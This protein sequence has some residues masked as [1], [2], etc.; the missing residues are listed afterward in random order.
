M[1]FRRSTGHGAGFD[2][3][4]IGVQPSE[5][6][7]VIFILALG[8]LLAHRD[9]ATSFATTLTPL[10]MAAGADAFNSERARPGNLAGFPA[11]SVCHV[12]RGRSIV[13]AT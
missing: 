6:A 13:V 11:D 9:L 5:F 3:G 1:R 2:S 4:G 10:A 7:K 8:S 12:V